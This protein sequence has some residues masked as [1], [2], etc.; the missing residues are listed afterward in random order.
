M[1][2]FDFHTYLNDMMVSNGNAHW[3]YFPSPKFCRSAE[4]GTISTR[5]VFNLAGKLIAKC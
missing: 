5:L 4:I 2:G 1:F 3:I